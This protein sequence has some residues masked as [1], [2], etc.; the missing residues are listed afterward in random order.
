M[1]VPTSRRLRKRS[2]F[3]RV[4]N[5]GL[6]VSTEPFLFQCCVVKKGPVAVRR[7]GVIASRRVGNAVKR[8]RGKRLVRE[9]F[10]INESSLP[11][12]CDLVVI[13]RSSFD[14]YSFEE[15]ETRYLR[16][17]MEISKKLKNS[18]CL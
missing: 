3:Q 4:R 15:L 9:L 1:G 17:C 10:R 11:S 5:K 7:L 16:M 2:E 12:D 8:N 13:L 14:R 18:E 6:R